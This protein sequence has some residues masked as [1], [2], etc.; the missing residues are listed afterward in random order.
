M[1]KYCDLH[2]E[3]TFDFM[4]I[5]FYVEIADAS[6]DSAINNS[7]QSFA[8]FYQSLEI[9]KEKMAGL[10]ENLVRQLY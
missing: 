10:H 6:R 5:T 2:K 7:L 3:N 1:Q 8:Q 4:P 9:N